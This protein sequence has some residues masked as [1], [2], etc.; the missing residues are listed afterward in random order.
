MVHLSYI[1]MADV[2]DIPRR[3]EALQ[4]ATYAP[5]ADASGAA[6]VVLVLGNAKQLMLLTEA[7]QHAGVHGSLAPMG[8]PTC[9]VLPAA[10]DSNRTAASFGCVGNRVYTGAGESDAYFAFPGEHLSALVGS[11]RTI[12]DANEALRAFHEQRA[13]EAPRAGQA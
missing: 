9:A 8:R 13:A 6:D 7:A 1:S 12:L 11:L 10:I 5:L 3:K 2:P 4:V